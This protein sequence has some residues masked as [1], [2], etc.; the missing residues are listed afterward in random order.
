MKIS[1]I[2]DLCDRLSKKLEAYTS[3]TIS[4][5]SHLV[6]PENDYSFYCE[7]GKELHYFK[8]AQELKAHMENLLNPQDDEDIDLEVA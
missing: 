8:T 6:G 3:I 4:R 2:N 7:T 5:H 1:E